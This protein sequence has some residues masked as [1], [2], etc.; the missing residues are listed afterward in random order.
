MNFYNNKKYYQALQL[1]EELISVFKGTSRAEPAYYYYA[2]SYF[3]TADYLTAAYHLQ[4]FA[5]TFP[6][7]EHAEECQYLNAYCYFL[8]SPAFTLDQTSTLDAIKQFQLFINRYPKSARV[9]ECNRQI[10]LLRL[11]LESKAFMNARLYYKTSEF[12]SATVAFGNVIKE[13]PNTQFKE[14]CLYLQVKSAYKYAEESIESKK[15]ERYKE[16]IEHYY[17]L[18]DNYPESQFLREA[19]SIFKDSQK[20]LDKIDK[21][22]SVTLQA[23]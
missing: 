5:K 22:K 1:L 8:D 3:E 15:K 4:N 2:K 17:K 11:K 9:E 12:R 14:E 7:S 23:N 19:E 18:L 13:F 21:D 16:T 20:V 6:A 10:D